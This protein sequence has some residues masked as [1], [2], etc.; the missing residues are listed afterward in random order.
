MSLSGLVNR[1]VAAP[2]PCFAFLRRI[3]LRSYLNIYQLPTLDL[4][5]FGQAS[6]VWRPLMAP[7][8]VTYMGS[9]SYSQCMNLLLH[10]LLKVICCLKM[11]RYVLNYLDIH[12]DN[13]SL[14]LRNLYVSGTVLSPF[15]ILPPFNPYNSLVR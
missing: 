11:L 14:L 12:I 13:N 10:S 8:C 6:P 3:E 4:E 15:H 2:K 9:T 1:K 7:S 5:S